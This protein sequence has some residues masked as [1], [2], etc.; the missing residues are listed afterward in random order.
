[1]AVNEGFGN[2]YI[3]LE[4]VMKAKFVQDFPDRDVSAFEFWF[5]SDR[6]RIDGSGRLGRCTFDER[7]YLGEKL[8]WQRFCKLFS[9]YFFI[10]D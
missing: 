10:I 6:G 2:Q 4:N 8:T 1:M 9:S 3:S 5:I 7:R